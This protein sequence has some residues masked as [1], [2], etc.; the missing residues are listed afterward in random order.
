MSLHSIYIGVGS[1]IERTRHCKAGVASL[2][3]YFSH[4]TISTVY[5]SAAIGFDGN[6][7]YNFVVKASTIRPVTDVVDILKSIER[8]HGRPDGQARFA[9]KTLDLDLLL[10]DSVVCEEDVQLPRAEILY[11][12]FVLKPLAEVAPDIIHPLLQ[13]SFRDLWLDFDANCQPLNPVTLH[14]NM[15]V[16]RDLI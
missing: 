5:E 2:A 14:F 15:E 6:D 13:R 8:E 1:N 11:N 10:Y 12:A 16:T 4:L 9:P 7:F 3:N